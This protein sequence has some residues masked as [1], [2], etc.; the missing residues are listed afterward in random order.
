MDGK[1]GDDVLYGNNGND[2]LLGGLDNDLLDG[3]NGRDVLDGGAGDDILTGGRGGD[4]FAFKPGFGH[5]TITDFSPFEDR[6]D[7]SGFHNWP[8]ISRTGST[9][10]LDFG[11]GDVLSINLDLGG[12][13]LPFGLDTSWFDLR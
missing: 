3:G 6:L 1:G 11:D 4:T 2:K 7:I 9:L 12:L 5:D 10:N 13:H 8:G